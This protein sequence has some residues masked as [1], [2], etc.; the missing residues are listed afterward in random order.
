MALTKDQAIR[1]GLEL[2]RLTTNPG[3]SI[4][5]DIL[6]QDYTSRI[7]TSQYADTKGREDSYKALVALDDLLGVINTLTFTAEQ[8]TL[9]PDEDE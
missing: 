2:R 7:V 4:A 6:R 9:N 3:F 8:H 1:A 5:V